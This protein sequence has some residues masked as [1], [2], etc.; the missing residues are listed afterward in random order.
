MGEET[1]EGK[2][3]GTKKHSQ[4]SKNRAVVKESDFQGFISLQRRRVKVILL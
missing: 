2:E 1:E 4:T 3:E